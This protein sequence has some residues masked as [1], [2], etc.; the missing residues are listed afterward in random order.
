[1]LAD[2]VRSSRRNSG[3]GSN[4]RLLLIIIVLGIFQEPFVRERIVEAGDAAI[5]AANIR[6]MES[7]WR[8]GIAS[9][10]LL[11][12]C[13][14]ALALISSFCCGPSAEISRCWRCS[15]TLFRSR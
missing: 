15:S 12:I 6:S 7:L 11:L 4:L 10:F 1:M 2:N 14:V 5:T 9:E 8:L 13:A 3:R